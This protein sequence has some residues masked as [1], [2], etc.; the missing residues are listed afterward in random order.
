MNFLDHATILV[1]GG[2]GG[3]GHVSFRKE[4]YI[5]R[6]GPDG[7]NG[8]HGGNVW[9]YSDANINNLSTCIIKKSFIAENGQNGKK[10]NSSG[11]KGKDIIISVPIGTKIFYIRNSHEIVIGNTQYHKQ[12]FIVAKGGSHGFGNHHFKSSICRVPRKCSYGKPGESKILELDFK[13]S[14][15]VGL[16][17]LTNVGRSLFMHVISNANPKISYYPFATRFPYLGV[18][19]LNNNRKF[20]CVDIPS[21]KIR[22]NL[23]CEIHFHKHLQNCQLI[24]HFVQIDHT[25]IKKTIKNIKI[26]MHAIKNLG[27]LR[28]KSFWL[29]FNKIDLAVDQDLLIKQAKFISHSSGYKN[30]FF[31]VSSHRED[32]LNVLLYKIYDFLSIKRNNKP[33]L[34]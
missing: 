10:N 9:I 2:K 18:V 7:G 34:T 32:N 27:N 16:F 5:P 14:A 12:K 13:L 30:N 17:G 8:G 22:K 1:Q 29:I 4:K 28:L 11:K 15:D 33:T 25:D 23:L 6:G 19:N 20:V 26:I 3:N 31:I 24:L 21:I